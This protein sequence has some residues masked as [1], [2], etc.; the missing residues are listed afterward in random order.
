M[1]RL[2]SLLLCLSCCIIIRHKY[3]LLFSH[4]VSLLDRS[5]QSSF[6]LKFVLS[7]FDTRIHFT[8]FFMNC[9]IVRHKHPFRLFFFFFHSVSPWDKRVHSSSVFFYAVKFQETQMQN[10][11]CQQLCQKWFLNKTYSWRTY[12]PRCD[13]AVLQDSENYWTAIPRVSLVSLNIKYIM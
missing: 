10:S 12:L 13:Q 2:Y 9:I 7:L 8:S 11:W 6:I 5:V 4:S 3:W 1:V